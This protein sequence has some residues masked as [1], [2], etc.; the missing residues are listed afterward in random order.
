MGEGRGCTGRTKQAERSK[1]EN[2]R[3][4]RK[5]RAIWGAVLKPNTVEA[6]YN[7]HIYES[8]WIKSP[9]NRVDRAPAGHVSLSN[10]ASSLGNGLLLIEYFRAKWVPGVP[11]AMWLLWGTRHEN[12]QITKAIGSS[13]QTDNEAPLLKTTLRQLTECG[14][15]LEPSPLQTSIPSTGRVS[16]CYQRRRKHQPSYKSSDLWEW[17]AHKMRWCNSGTQFVGVTNWYLICVRPPP[18]DGTYAQSCLGG[19]EPETSKGR[20]LGGTN[21]Y[22]SDKGT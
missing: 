20:V 21:Y 9:N 5:T 11:G 16:A 7:T 4:D 2:M 6:S 14:E 8:H 10:G 19:E 17:P 13:L 3:R 22:Y 15:V 12:P 18:W 1:E